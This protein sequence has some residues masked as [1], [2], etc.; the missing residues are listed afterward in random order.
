MATSRL[1]PRYCLQAL[2]SPLACWV[3]PAQAARPIA[4]LLQLLL[5]RLPLLPMLDPRLLPTVQRVL[6][7]PR[8]LVLVLLQPRTL[9]VVLPQPRTLV[10]VPMR[11]QLQALVLMRPCMLVV[12]LKLTRPE[13]LQL[14]QL[15]S[16]PH[17]LTRPWVH[18]LLRPCCMGLQLPVVPVR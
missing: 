4:A 6:M 13:V 18:Q 3:Q 7:Q 15:A 8:I 10:V 5:L 2:P 17:R 12:V 11:R 16:L 9:A 14:L 1:Q